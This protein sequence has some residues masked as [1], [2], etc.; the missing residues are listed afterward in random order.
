MD[1]EDAGAV[2]VR[3]QAAGGGDRGV[4]R[5]VADAVRVEIG[6][7]HGDCF[8]VDESIAVAVNHG[9]DAQ[10]KD[11]LMVRGE[12]AG[13]NDGAPWEV[14]DVVVYGLCGEDAGGADFVVQLCGLVK[15]E[16][17]NVFVVGGC[18]VGISVA[19]RS[20]SGEI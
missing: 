12:D 9:V 13:V 4:L 11:M 10:R 6:A 15:D 20:T 7:W 19:A 2:E 3:V 8:R 14:G 17:E 5:V 1:F 18:S 16:C